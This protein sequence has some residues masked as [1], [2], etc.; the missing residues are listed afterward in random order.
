[1]PYM[2][3]SMK[4]QNMDIQFKTVR[5]HI[6]EVLIFP[7]CLQNLIYCFIFENLD[8]LKLLGVQGLIKGS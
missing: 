8:I 4:P 6:P 2:V 7:F 1:M 5:Q 3:V